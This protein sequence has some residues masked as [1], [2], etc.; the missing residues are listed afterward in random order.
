MKKLLFGLLSIALLVLAS[1]TIENNIEVYDFCIEAI[2]DAGY[3]PPEETTPTKVLDCK[4]NSEPNAYIFFYDIEGSKNGERYY[5][6][7]TYLIDKESA[8]LQRFIIDFE[9][10]NSEEYK[11]YYK[12]I[13]N[14]NIVAE[15]YNTYDE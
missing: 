4:P 6:R 13:D 15:V 3:T 7:V 1:C 2:R 11:A 14:I 8:E 9:N 12:A 5:P 10:E